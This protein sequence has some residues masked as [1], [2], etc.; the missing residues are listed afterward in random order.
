M[1]DGSGPCAA[2][3]M[4]VLPTGGDSNAILCKFCFEREIAYRRERNRDLGED[5][6]FKIPAWE[7][8]KVYE[9]EPEAKP[10]TGKVTSKLYACSQCGHQERHD[11]NHYGE[12]YSWGR[13]SV[14][15]KC[16]PFRRPTTWICQEKP[17]EGM[18][19]PEP[20]KLTS[21]KVTKN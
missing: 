14:C 3:E 6:K 1:C 10:T 7:D 18:G 5:C 8:C 13:V 12:T 19:M 11:T 15:P 21:L 2:G 9:Q 17:P 4:R 16:P 20:W